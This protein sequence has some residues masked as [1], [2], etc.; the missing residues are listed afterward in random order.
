MRN[1]HPAIRH[2][3]EPAA[4]RDV[5]RR[6]APKWHLYGRALEHPVHGVVMLPNALPERDKQ[7]WAMRVRMRPGQ[8]FS[9][10]TAAELHD[11][12]VAWAS[13]R[14]PIE[15]G[16][17]RPVR[18]PRRPQVRGHQLQ[19]GVLE[20]VPAGPGWL[21]SVEDTWCLLAQV[22]TKA[23]LLAAGDFL[24]SGRTRYEEP[25]SSLI[26]LGVAAAR[27]RGCAGGVLRSE[28][29]P[30]IRTGV[31]SPAESALR[32]VIIEAGLSEPLTNCPVRVRGSTLHADLGYPRWRIAIEYDGAYHFGENKVKQAKR[33]ISR[34]RA[35]EEA[36]WK[37]LRATSLDL[38]RH[39]EFL[40]ALRAAI[41]ARS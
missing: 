32:L 4:V 11:L 35:M 30:L 25:R 8:F 13:A 19:A 34:A 16:G 3:T 37:V 27:F 26:R 23:E 41:A 31:E 21:P 9:R 36:G 1:R 33:D 15:I 22:A 6:G 28:V 39:G 2:L 40:H 18:P 20:Y 12:P 5:L 10:R 38:D 17:I 14:A 24:V 29:I 7:I